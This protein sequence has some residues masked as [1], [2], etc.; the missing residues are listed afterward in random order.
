MSVFSS[1]VDAKIS[2]IKEELNEIK[3]NLAHAVKSN[4]FSSANL[5]SFEI[6]TNLIDELEKVHT[7]YFTKLRLTASLFLFV[8]LPYTY[9][10]TRTLIISQVNPFKC[11]LPALVYF[12]GFGLFA[13]QMELYYFRGADKPL[14]EHLFR[15]YFPDEPTELVE[16][17]IRFFDYHNTIKMF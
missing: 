7:S 1:E 8:G 12:F 10:R 11:I 17:R 4:N 3:T 14:K 13:K 2:A 15:K 5:S 16:S 9:F 6:P